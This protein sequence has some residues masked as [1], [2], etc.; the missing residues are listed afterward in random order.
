MIMQRCCVLQRNSKAA[1]QPEDEPYR[2]S[3]TK[4]THQARAAQN[5]PK[6]YGDTEY[7]QY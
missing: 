1:Q 5:Q 7:Q 2:P 3:S 4:L 6:Q